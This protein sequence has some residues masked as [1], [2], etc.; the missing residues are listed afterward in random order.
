M[1]KLDFLKIKKDW[2]KNNT[3][4][5]PNF[6]WMIIFYTGF[7]L[8]VAA[9]VFDFL[10]FMKVSRENMYSGSINTEQLDKISE[11]RIEKALDIFEEKTKASFKTINL[12]S[13]FSDP[14]I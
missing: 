1:L 14:S 3:Q 2:K 4:P 11:G 6:Y 7:L 10:L 5:D 9:F 13:Q 12:P 8:T